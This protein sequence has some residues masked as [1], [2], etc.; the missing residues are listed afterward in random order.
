MVIKYLS[1]FITC[2]H[3]TIDLKATIA[4]QCSYLANRLKNDKSKIQRNTEGIARSP[5]TARPSASREEVSP[6]ISESPV[7]CNS[8]LSQNVIVENMILSTNYRQLNL[9]LKI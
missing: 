1:T 9:Y 8:K 4:Y 7:V 5:K 6:D 3:A 2:I